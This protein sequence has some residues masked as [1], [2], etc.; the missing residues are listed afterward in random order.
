[1]MK[2][3]KYGRERLFLTAILL[4]AAL[5]TC[6]GIW[7]EGTA[8]V[9][10]TAAVQSM[11]QS[12]RNFFFAAFD[13]AGFI[14]VD[15]P[16]PGLWLQCLF[17]AVFGVHGW[18]VILP[19][20]LCSVASVSVLYRLAKR[21]F[22]TGVGLLSA[23]FLALTPIF[24][25]VSRTNNL[26]AGL[27][28]VCLLALDALDTAVRKGSL[29]WLIFAMVLTGVGFNVK[30]LEA[31]LIVPAMVLTYLLGTRL[32]LR[33]RIGH[34]AISAAVLLAVS[35]SWV[36][37]VDLTPAS[38]RPYV[39]SSTSNSALE[40][41]L[42]YNGIE[43]LV[44]STGSGSNQPSTGYAGIRSMLTAAEA[45]ADRDGGSPDGGQ[46]SSRSGGE[47]GKNGDQAGSSR[48]S[49]ATESGAVTD[50]MPT[51]PLET[52]LS[53]GSSFPSGGRP[54]G[55]S[56][57]GE[58]NTSGIN[59]GGAAGPLRM[60]NA[61][62]SGQAS[63]LLPL[64]MIGLLLLLLRA[65]KRRKR[66]ALRPLLLWGGLF[67]AMYGY[68]SVASHFHRYYMSIFAPVLAVL[69]AAALSELWKMWRGREG[70][71]GLF[72]RFPLPAALFLTGT[73]QLLILSDNSPWLERLGIPISVL[74]FGAGLAFLFLSR[75]FRRGKAVLA[76]GMAG[77]L[78]APAFWS[79]TPI[80]YGTQASIPV[81]GPVL[82]NVSRSSTR[83]ANAALVA[84]LE[85]HD[86]GETYLM[87]TAT[88]S[89]AAPVMLETGRAVMA[90]GGYKGSDPAI[91]LEKFKELVEEGQIRYFLAAGGPYRSDIAV[92]A[93]QNGT[94]VSTP[95]AEASAGSPAFGGTLYD[96]SALRAS[97]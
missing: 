11:L 16:A 86:G 21:Q 30:M 56:A 69:A 81:A 24:V 2:L 35:L 60:F 94:A 95:E 84:Y 49:G 20:A 57:Y 80:L 43:R 42:Y 14:S 46:S 97:H 64:S 45:D 53:A 32:R 36:T 93:E 63:W 6:W 75:D 48:N 31:F 13:P 19:E 44:N 37:A 1:M 74:T 83:T 47:T 85:A 18:S 38:D 50:E 40:L 66:E 79:L 70:W 59:E 33:R 9:Y 28:L 10:Y 51:P 71:E 23:L 55:S 27:V 76:L 82:Q 73:V 26:D 72:Y 52:R 3:T 90:V 29:K 7:R 87:A 78:I 91:T 67:A 68:F 61:S 25:A 22:G 34:L 88:A 8:N 62:M 54:G 77:L 92:W 12:P 15:K 39:G 5:L 58:T 41:A 4:L 17:A 96:L 89:T 65:L